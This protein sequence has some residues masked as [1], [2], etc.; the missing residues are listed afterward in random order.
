MHPDSP[1]LRDRR[2]VLLGG[3]HSHL[4]VVRRLGRSSGVRPRMTL[5]SR[6]P[7]SIY[8]GMLPGHIAGLYPAGA[9]GIDLTELCD[10]Y[11]ATFHR[12]D[13]TG[14]DRQRKRVLLAD[15]NSIDYDLLSINTGAAPSLDR[16]PGAAEHAIAVKPLQRFM[17]QLDAIKAHGGPA[18]DE[19]MAIVGG[20][21]G[22]V[23]LALALDVRMHHRKQ[24]LL[25]TGR[26]GLL[27]EHNPRVRRQVRACLQRRDI[28]LIEGQRVSH[29]HRHGLRLDEG[30][31]LASAATLLAT[32]VRGPAWLG[33][34]GLALDAAG[35]IRVRRTLAAVGDPAVFAAG[36]VASIDDMPLARA[37]V[38]AVRQGPLLATNLRRALAGK[39]QRPF[40]PQRATL[41]LIS[42]GDRYAIASRGRFSASGYWVWRWKD[43]LDRRFIRRYSDGDQG[44]EPVMRC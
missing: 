40:R 25:I 38:F 24:I 14:I 29:I 28:R 11:A 22:G 2:L 4:E 42:T 5:V 21:A 7:V 12:G 26:R 3:G 18:D 19:P 32:A 31:E 44:D 15:G 43:W 30:R 6:D 35:F 20:G 37:G 27:P 41:A 13:V 33:E 39:P 10:R 9:I 34:T 23:E 1:E 17:Q 8:S 16:I 36:D